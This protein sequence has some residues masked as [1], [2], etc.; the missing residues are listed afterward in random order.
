M[1]LY[2][3]ERA[4]E[5]EAA[6]VFVCVRIWAYAC[7]YLHMWD[8]TCL[9]CHELNRR[10]RL[11][12]SQST[13]TYKTLLPLWEAAP[14][15]LPVLSFWWR[16]RRPLETLQTDNTLSHTQWEGCW[17]LQL[18]SLLTNPLMSCQ[19]HKWPITDALRWGFLFFDPLL[20]WCVFNYSVRA[21]PRPP[22]MTSFV[23]EVA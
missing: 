5:V 20:T 13:I 21:H 15:S 6:T 18:K 11:G 22:V 23:G 7:R 17:H 16:D 12:T 3:S 2:V 19:T 1:H 10:E 8:A 14:Q 4:D 9:A